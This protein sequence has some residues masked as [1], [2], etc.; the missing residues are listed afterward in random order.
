MDLF[1]QQLVNG[2]GVGSQYALWAVGYGLVC[3]VL[4]LMHFAH[5]D[6]LVFSGLVAFSLVAIGAPFMLAVVVAAA[7]G[8]VIAV[9]IEKVA[10]A[11]LM[12]RKEPF[13]AF[14]AALAAAYVLRNISTQ[15]WGVNTHV[16][17]V[18]I[19]PDPVSSVGGVSIR[20]FALIS[21]ALAIVTVAVFQYCLRATR[22]GRAILAT[23]EDR[24]TAGLMGISTSRVVAGVYALSGA[25]GVLGLALYVGNTRTL[26]IGLGFAITLKAFVAVTIG[27]LRSIEGT[28]AAGLALGVSESLI[29][30]YLST[31]WSDVIVY[32]VL[33]LVLIFRPD[34][35]VG[36][37]DVIRA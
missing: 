25:I 35:I 2:V 17:P 10:Y 27:G 29:G 7:V 8:A 21:L 9:T 4:G 32:A 14:V 6:T 30:T 19:L 33:I 26:T 12:A 24:D 1:I 20:W 28:V 15:V 13:L 11:P 22:G 3:Q 23:A 16:F 31:Q 36:R 34:G 37:K 18:G 5:G